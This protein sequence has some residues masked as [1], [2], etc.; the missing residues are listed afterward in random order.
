MRKKQKNGFYIR[1]FSGVPVL[2]DP[3][4]ATTGTTVWGINE[5]MFY[6]RE[7]YKTTIP[8]KNRWRTIWLALTKGVVEITWEKK[9]TDNDKNLVL[10]GR[11]T[12]VGWRNP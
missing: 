10:E 7:K 11:R 4:I 6:I 3:T 5:A 9:S 8:C 2:E 1:E 12:E